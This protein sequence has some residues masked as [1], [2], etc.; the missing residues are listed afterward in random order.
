MSQLSRTVRCD[1]RLTLPCA[2][3]ALILHAILTGPSA[4]TVPA[5][6]RE[7]QQ[8]Q[9]VPEEFHHQ[10][11]SAAYRDNIRPCAELLFATLLQVWYISKVCITRIHADT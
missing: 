4:S 3:L 9:E 11:D 10:S 2:S 8:W 5:Q 7:L 6:A 1:V